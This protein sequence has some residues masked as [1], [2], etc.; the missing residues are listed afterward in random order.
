[1]LVSPS[2]WRRRVGATLFV[3]LGAARS[4]HCRCGASRM[5][6]SAAPSLRLRRARR[7]GRGRPR[8]SCLSTGAAAEAFFGCGCGLP[9]LSRGALKAR[10]SRRWPASDRFASV[11][12]DSGCLCSLVRRAERRSRAEHQLLLLLLSRMASSQYLSTTRVPSVGIALRHDASLGF[13]L[14]S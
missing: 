1:M 3:S 4:F 9:Q 5:R 10:I 8:A 2:P 7:S 12:D 14:A 11:C 13:V 6:S